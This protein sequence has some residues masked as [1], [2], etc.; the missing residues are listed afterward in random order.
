MGKLG[1][2]YECVL[3]HRMPIISRKGVE[4]R[5]KQRTRFTAKSLGWISE[6]PGLVS[7]LGK[8]N[9]EVLTLCS[10]MIHI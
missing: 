1:R 3:C 9:S 7:E 6:R 4:P 8:Q 2:L 5:R 10:S